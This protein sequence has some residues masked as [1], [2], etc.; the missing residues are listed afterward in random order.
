MTAQFLLPPGVPFVDGK[1]LGQIFDEEL[2]PFRLALDDA[3]RDHVLWNET[4]WPAF[5][6]GEPEACLRRQLREAFARRT[7]KVKR[8]RGQRRNRRN[9]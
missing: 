9:R 4:G 5:W 6:T 8:G 1:N 7:P 2:A 3:E